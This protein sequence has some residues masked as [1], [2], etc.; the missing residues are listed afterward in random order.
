VTVVNADDKAKVAAL[1]PHPLDSAFATRGNTTRDLTNGL[2]NNPMFQ[3]AVAA[4]LKAKQ[5]RQ[6]QMRQTPVGPTPEQA[7]RQAFLETLNQPSAEGIGAPQD[8]ARDKAK[9]E[10]K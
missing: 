9:V 1:P 4:A 10:P 7:A 5:E 6:A 8:K 3:R 2:L